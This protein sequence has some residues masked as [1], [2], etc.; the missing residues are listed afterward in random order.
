MLPSLHGFDGHLKCVDI[1]LLVQGSP[2]KGTIFGL[3]CA[4]AQAHACAS[5]RDVPT[6]DK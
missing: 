1:P 3:V 4:R 2:T 6:H 5:Q